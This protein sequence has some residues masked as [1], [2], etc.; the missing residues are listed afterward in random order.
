PA[1]WTPYHMLAE[2]CQV[3]VE[4]GAESVQLPFRTTQNLPE[5]A[6]V[7][8]VRYDPEPVIDVHVYQNDQ[9]QRYSGRTS[10]KADAL[11]TGDLS[12]NLTNLQL[13]DSATYTCSVRD[14]GDELSR[15]QIHDGG[16]VS[17]APSNNVTVLACLM[18]VA[19]LVFI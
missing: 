17:V 6:T 4:E 16:S 15:S 12:L 9:N 18:F 2:M 3:E 14:F 1:C 11:E 19:V 5:D 13:S 7:E 8:W 10:M